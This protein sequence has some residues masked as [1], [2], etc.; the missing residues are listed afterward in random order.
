MSHSTT[1]TRKSGGSASRAACTCGSGWVAAYNCS[2][3]GV[4]PGNR[5]V[6]S[7]SAS[8]RIRCRRRTMSRNRFV[9]I[10]C[11]QPSTV[12]GA[13]SASERNTRTNVS[14]VR[15]SASCWLPES[16]Y[17][18]RYTRAEWSRTSCS[19]LGATQPSA[20]A[21]AG[22]GCAGPTGPVALAPVTA[23]GSQ[24]AGPD[25]P[26]RGAG[27]SAGGWLVVRGRRTDVPTGRA[28]DRVPA[29][30]G[31]TASSQAGRLNGHPSRAADLRPPLPS[32]GDQRCRTAPRRGLPDRRRGVR[33]Q[34]RGRD[35]GEGRGPAPGAHLGE[36]VRHTAPRGAGGRG[37]PG[38]APARGRGRGGGVVGEGGGGGGAG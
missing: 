7:G 38:G 24:T 10:R 15:S 14:W 25:T 12:P 20:A 17:A 5:S 35:P 27:S 23:P 18:S 13:K 9:V 34:L 22:S 4:V 26:P 3:A 11:N 1:A 29:G 28:G 33:R 2:G 21:A 8:N 30:T 36:R 32:P 37:D 6:S 31:P 16:R 19:H